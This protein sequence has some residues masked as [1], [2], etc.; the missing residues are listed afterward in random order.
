L[1]NKCWCQHCY[2]FPV[3][4]TSVGV[5]PTATPTPCT[6]PWGDWSPCTACA[7]RRTR[8]CDT[9]N[10]ACDCNA[11]IE[12]QTR[13]CP[14][15]TTPAPTTPASTPAPSQYFNKSMQFNYFISGPFTTNG[16]FKTTTL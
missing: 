16:I 3:C 8:T 12:L 7:Q 10:P 1:S 6:S 4:L 15:C 11:A 9:S 2:K 13:A 14:E 5:F